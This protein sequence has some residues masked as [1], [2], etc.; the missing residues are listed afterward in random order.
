M[1]NADG[2]VDDHVLGSRDL[3][4][5]DKSESNFVESAR[6]SAPDS[7]RFAM[8]SV[9]PESVKTN[10]KPSG[11]I[12]PQPVSRRKRSILKRFKV[13]LKPIRP[14]SDVSWS[15]SDDPH[16][17]EGQ[18]KINTIPDMKIEKRPERTKLTLGSEEAVLHIRELASA[19][20]NRWELFHSISK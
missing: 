1:A 8:P 20:R 7:A 6:M 3:Q 2:E 10:Q 4:L 13:T 19:A 14:P 11:R 15:D 5:L 16:S 12:P 9:R 17:L 18:Q